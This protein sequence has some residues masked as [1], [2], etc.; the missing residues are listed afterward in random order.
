MDPKLVEQL[1]Y[2]LLF[3]DM[4]GKPYDDQNSQNK[5][6]RDFAKANNLEVKDHKN[7]VV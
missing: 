3:K 2:D 5:M 4:N 7:L 1:L 6:I